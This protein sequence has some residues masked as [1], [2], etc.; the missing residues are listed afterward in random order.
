[1][2]AT[3]NRPSLFQRAIN[4][5][6]RLTSGILSRGA[7]SFLAAAAGVNVSNFVFH[8][9]ISR[10]LGPAHY[11]AVGAILSILG[12]LAVPVGA[13]QLAVTQAII[14]HETRNEQFSLSQLMWRALVVGL[15]AM[16]AFDVLIPVI[17]G[18]LH[19]NSPLPLVL[20]GAWIPLATVGAMATG[21]LIGEYRFRAVAVATFVGGGPIR[22]LVG[23]A[24][25]WLG[26]GITGAVVATLFAQ[27][28]VTLTLLF[29]AR[30][31][32]RSRPLVEMVQTSRY[33]MFLS[34]ASIG[35]YTALIGIDT[36][37][38]R[39][40]F[41]AT[42]AGQYAAGAVAAHIA[43]FVPG[44]L[45][46][47]AFPH[48]VSGQGTGATSRRVFV[49]AMKIT[50][51]LGVI[52]ATALT[53][54]SSLV[55]HVLFGA[56]YTKAI[57]IVG[58][59]AFASAI[60]GVINVLVYL[61]LARRSRFALTPWLGVAIASILITI[62]HQSATSVAA[63]ML[64]VSLVTLLVI[65]IPALWAIAGA[66]AHDQAGLSALVE[67]PNADLDL[68]L[69]VPFYNP[70]PRVKSHFEEIIAALT[71]S[72]LSFEIIA[73]SDGSTDNSEAELAPLLSEYLKIVRFEQNR[74][75]GAALRAGLSAGRGEYLGFIDGDGDIP[76]GLLLDLIEII[77]GQSPE[78][79]Y[80]SKRHPRSQVDYPPLR[81]LYSW[82]YQQVNRVFFRL[83]VRD[84]QTGIK[85]LHRDVLKAVLPRMVEKR[86]AFDLELFVV[87]RQQGFRNF[88]EMPVTIGP[89]F[90]ST[91]SV[92][93]VRNMLID[94]LAIFYRLR[95]LRFYERDIHGKTEENLLAQ[96]KVERT[97]STLFQSERSHSSRAGKPLRILILNWRDVTHPKAGGAEVYTHHVASEW[98]REGH[99]VTLFCAAVKN[100][101]SVE[102]Y[103]GVKVIRRGSGLSVYRHAKKYYQRKGG[104][105]YDVV[106]EEINTRPFFARKWVR[107]VP[108]VALIHQVCRELWFYQAPLP[109]AIAGRY[110]F[111]RKWLYG[112]R[113]VRI[114]T[115]SESSKESLK[116]YGLTNVVVVPEGH[117]PIGNLPA[118]T[119][120]TSPTVVF[121][122]RLEAHK[123]PDEAILAFRHLRKSMPTAVLWII[124]TGSLEDKLRMSAPDGVQF[125]GKISATEKVER[126]ARAHVLIATSVREGWGL[127]VTEAADVGTPTIAYNVP[128]L[129]DS[130]MASNGILSPP[131]PESLGALL[132]QHLPRWVESGPILVTPGGITSWEEVARQILS[133]AMD[134]SEHVNPTKAST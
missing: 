95:I 22:L 43:L 88:V 109:V 112:Y 130:V 71:S 2:M 115:V 13:A 113:H 83:P 134:P 78:I 111:E 81:H 19:L 75:K 91:I 28:F 56:S 33:N 110:F 60:I 4:T 66:S 126:L 16:T 65:F 125:L 98:V 104:G 100:R 8:I 52:T 119:R 85:V 74:G 73:V 7:F 131:N 18:F 53:V 116:L 70:G 37:L 41:T 45:V 92:R 24:L 64:A 117:H 1:M 108:L 3:R 80:G 122:G 50:S 129:S 36:F 61:H 105:H 118:V 9:I 40:F 133:A 103:E 94:T 101:P 21:A 38:A 49:Q 62:H 86:F 31:K 25:V 132:E 84:T 82:T 14:G 123:R 42:M 63:A 67:L 20:V 58:I 5:R 93:S 32:I 79:I 35:G 59:L 102:D 127:V 97:V 39:H 124:G 106:V 6:S 120:D 23:G 96:R 27:A 69:V 57:D 90:S 47:I 128:G 10:L 54:L 15:A 30:H 72:Q 44:A 17:D 48:W 46:T 11:G 99:E 68:T 55:V 89:R 77:R 12:L 121:V 76:A 26:F 29:F 87:A 114:I 34:I 51:A 107:D